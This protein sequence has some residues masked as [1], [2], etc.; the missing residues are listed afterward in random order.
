MSVFLSPPLPVQIL[1]V[2]NVLVVV[3]RWYGGI[4]LGPDR[5]KHINNCARNILVEEGYAASTVSRWP[6][7]PYESLSS[8][9]DTSSVKLG[10]T[11]TRP[12]AGYTCCIVL[13][14]I[15]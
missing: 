10:P 9:T 5:F 13:S 2:R 14:V 6:R 12:A 15:S 3:S 8:S 7:P 1:D 4:L 11:V